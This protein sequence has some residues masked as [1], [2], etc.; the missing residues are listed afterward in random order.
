MKTIFTIIF[1]CQQKNLTSI[2]NILAIFCQ[3]ISAIITLT[4]ERIRPKI[5]PSLLSLLLL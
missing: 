5:A 2:S 4:P 1:F 3:K